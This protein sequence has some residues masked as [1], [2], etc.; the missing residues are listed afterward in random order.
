MDKNKEDYLAHIVYRVFNFERE[1][2]SFEDLAN[3]NGW[4]S[5]LQE[6]FFERY[7][8]DFI[9]LFAFEAAIEILAIEL[10]R[11]GNYLVPK[12]YRFKKNIIENLNERFYE[13]DILEI[14]GYLF[15]IDLGYV[16][17][18]ND[19]AETTEYA[20]NEADRFESISF[21]HIKEVLA[22]T[23]EGILNT[24]LELLKLR[25]YNLSMSKDFYKKLP[26]DVDKEI[27]AEIIKSVT[28]N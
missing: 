27:M 8:T 5:L 26:F 3:K 24:Q 16:S 22:V 23:F 11:M 1:F 18:C 12:A 28:G 25:L 9:E 2:E 14:Y 10:G 7:K 13:Q 20:I 19:S 21:T 17:I 15:D 4:S 6:N